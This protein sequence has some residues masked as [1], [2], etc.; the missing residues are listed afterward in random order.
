MSRIALHNVVVNDGRLTQIMYNLYIY[1]Y[2]YKS[3]IVSTD[4]HTVNLITHQLLKAKQDVKKI[5]S[6][7]CFVDIQICVW[8]DKSF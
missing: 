6:V 7:N 2:I 1:N 3:I 4:V 8:L 5:T